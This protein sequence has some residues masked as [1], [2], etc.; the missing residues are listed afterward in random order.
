MMQVLVY[1]VDDGSGTWKATDWTRQRMFVTG[2]SRD[3]AIAKFITAWNARNN[4]DISAEDCR[5]F[6]PILVTV[7]LMQESEHWTATAYSDRVYVVAAPT[8]EQVR[9][10][11]ITYWNAE[12]PYAD[13]TE[14]NV[15]WVYDD[16][17]PSP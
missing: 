3:D 6:G 15:D 5:F 1:P 17:T 8:E 7:H 14:M 10:D 2:N 16:W 11:F 9:A 13:V 4:P 12:S